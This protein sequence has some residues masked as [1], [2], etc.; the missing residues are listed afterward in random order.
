M[1]GAW[2]G[3]GLGGWPYARRVAVPELRLGR[4]GGAGLGGWGGSR[5]NPGNNCKRRGTRFMPT[6][7]QATDRINKALQTIPEIGDL[8]VDAP[9]F[10]RW[11]RGTKVA[12]SNAF[13]ETSDHVREFDRIRFSSVIYTIGGD[14][15][16]EIARSYRDGLIEAS[17]LLQ[18]ML[19][20]IEEYWE[21]DI[22]AAPIAMAGE[23]PEQQV[24]NRVFVVHGRDD[25]VK[26]TVAR[27]LEH[28]E[29]E[30]IILHEQ[31]NQSRTIIDKFEEYSQVDFA[32]ILC[33]PDDV[34]KLNSEA[35]EFRPRPRQNVVLEW[36]F[37]FGY[38]GPRASLCSSKGRRRNTV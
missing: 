12:V 13:G 20:E 29:L 16:A 14:N 25:G 2:R 22:S 36:G 30:A 24:S 15:S 33:T 7:S 17:A 35:D 38:V 18:S 4:R 8:N 28:L 21:D 37:F 19:D 5:Y 6:K 9:E 34:G 31:P 1:L 10:V 11:R 32:V 27:F 26:N 3:A 23:I